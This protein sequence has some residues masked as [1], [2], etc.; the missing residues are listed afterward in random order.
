MRFPQTI[1]N[2]DFEIVM[3]EAQLAGELESWDTENR[4]EREDTDPFLCRS[5]PP[6]FTF[7]G[8]TLTWTARRYIAVY[9]RSN[10]KDP[11]VLQSVKRRVKSTPYKYENVFADLGDAFNDNYEKQQLQ[12]RR[13][14]IFERKCRE[15]EATEAMNIVREALSHKP[16][17]R[18]R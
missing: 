14:R 10:G 17:G 11:W 7:H 6:P 3:M 9:T 18:K 13:E 8:Q 2:D 12:G 1:D 16:K 15:A 5:N 4:I